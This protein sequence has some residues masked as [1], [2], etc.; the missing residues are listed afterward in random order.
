MNYP[1]ASSGVSIEFFKTPQGGGIV[2]L[3][4]KDVCWDH[5]WKDCAIRVI[6]LRKQ[7]SAILSQAGA[8][9]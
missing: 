5:D 1:A 7:I 8:K 3:E 2:P 4:I 6:E 9:K